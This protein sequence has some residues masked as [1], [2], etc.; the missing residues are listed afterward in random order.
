MTDTVVRTRGLTRVYGEGPTAVEALRGIDL[1]IAGGTFVVLLGPSG[2]GKTTLL[3][4]IGGIDRPTAGEVRV[5]GVDVGAARGAEL[6]RYRRHGVGFVF[7][8]FNLVPTLTALENVELIAALAGAGT[9]EALAALDDVG[10]A[11]LADRFP[12][13]LSGGQQQRVAIARAL[14]KSAPLILGDEPTGA[15]DRANG[16]AVLALLRAACDE[17]GRVVL[18]VSHDP[19]VARVADRVLHLVDGRIVDDVTNPAP[20][21]AAEVV[22]A[23]TAGEEVTA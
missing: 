20:L 17:A 11:D 15:L 21:G 3:N 6:A 12:G 1:D 8:F 10:I 18:V 23:L 9:P 4:L 5:D 7:Q 22:A 13:Q 2:S 16:A 19:D 14:A